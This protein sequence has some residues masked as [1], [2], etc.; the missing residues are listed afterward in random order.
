[1]SIARSL[2]RKLEAT[3]DLL[4][5]KVF[6]FQ[7][8][9]DIKEEKGEGRLRLHNELQMPYKIPGSHHLRDCTSQ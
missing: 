4:G 9:N 7:L 3:E 6:N 1:M 8:D 5:M 2:K